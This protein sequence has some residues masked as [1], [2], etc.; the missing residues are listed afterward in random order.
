MPDLGSI[1]GSLQWTGAVALG[2]CYVAAVLGVFLTFRIL[3]FPDL[4]IEGSFP[5]GAGLAG[6]LIVSAGWP[7]WATLLVAIGGG[8]LAGAATGLLATRLKINGLLASILVMIALYSI[9]LRVLGLR[10]NLPLLDAPTIFDPVEAW[11]AALLGVPAAGGVVQRYAAILV[12]ALIDALLIMGLHWFL[13]TDLGLALR[14]TGD[15]EP[16]ASAQGISN[17]RMKILG[18]AISNGLIALAGALFAPYQGFADVSIGRGLIVIG[19]AAV[20]IG[21]V[22]L[23]PQHLS[24][25]LIAAAAGSLI[26]RLFVTLALNYTGR[27]GL[28]ETDLQFVTALIV[29]AAMAVP[30]LRRGGTGQRRLRLLASSRHGDKSV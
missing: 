22:L 14:A 26:Y 21:E 17:D 18:L 3:N 7:H 30:R 1:F 29:I 2:L 25:A 13:H 16:M 28:Q 9:N 12:F 27:I 15:N 20:I 19:L 6:I 10:S 5:L 11:L 4:T 23:N 24:T 8:A